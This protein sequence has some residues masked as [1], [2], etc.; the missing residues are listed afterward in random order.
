M[1]LRTPRTQGSYLLR[2]RGLLMRRYPRQ[3]LEFYRFVSQELDCWIRVNVG[4][5]QL[6]FWLRTIQGGSQ[7]RRPGF[8]QIYKGTQA[9]M[10]TSDL[11]TCES[12]PIT[13]IAVCVAVELHQQ[14]N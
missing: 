11:L 14:A 12:S 1:D 3:V 8:L 10:M 13:H 7:V 6:R 4:G 5:T 9:S 2:T